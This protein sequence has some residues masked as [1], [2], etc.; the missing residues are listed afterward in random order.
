MRLLTIRLH[1]SSILPQACKV[2]AAPVGQPQIE[3]LFAFFFSEA[4][5]DFSLF[6]RNRPNHADDG[7]PPGSDNGAHRKNT[8]PF[9]AF[10]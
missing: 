1:L 8:P 3:N 2:R 6:N 9:A 5:M 10:Y 4:S 7:L